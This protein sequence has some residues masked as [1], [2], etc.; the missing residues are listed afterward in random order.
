MCYHNLKFIVNKLDPNKPLSYY[1][2]PAIIKEY[3]TK[4]DF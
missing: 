2:T 4:E 1:L 3:S